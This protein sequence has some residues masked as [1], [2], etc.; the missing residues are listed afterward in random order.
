[1]GVVVTDGACGVEMAEDWCKVWATVV[2]RCVQM[3][4]LLKGPLVPVRVMVGESV[5]AMKST[6]DWC[7]SSY[8]LYPRD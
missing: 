6:F 5:E 4:A 2:R 1:M 7:V 8:N 3:T